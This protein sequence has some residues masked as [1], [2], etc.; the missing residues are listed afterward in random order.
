HNKRGRKTDI[1]SIL[2]SR[3]LIPL[4]DDPEDYAALTPGHFLIGGSLQAIPETPPEE[5]FSLRSNY[6]HVQ[7]LAQHFW[8]RWSGDYLHTLQQRSKWQLGSKSISLEGALV[9]LKEDNLP[10]MLWKMG[11]ITRLFPGN[12]SVVRVVEIKTSGG[13]FKR[14]VNKVCILPVESAL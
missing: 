8:K 10:P 12:D 7:L 2:N 5:N 14:A 1:K 9:L 13:I 4:T 6:H 3:P 11:R